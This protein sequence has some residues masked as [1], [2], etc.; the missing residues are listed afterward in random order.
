MDEDLQRI[1]DAK[2]EA[3]EALV[4]TAVFRHEDGQFENVGE[5]MAFLK[6][7]RDAVAAL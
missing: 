7:W 2:K 6:T 4:E 3:V 5:V 1:L